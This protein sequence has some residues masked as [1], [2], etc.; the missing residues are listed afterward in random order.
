MPDNEN[1]S[2]IKSRQRVADHSEVFTNLRKVNVMLGLMDS[3][4]PIEAMLNVIPQYWHNSICLDK[5]AIQKHLFG[6]ANG[7][8]LR[9]WRSGFRCAIE[10]LTLASAWIQQ[11]SQA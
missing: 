2:Q 5:K 3:T 4:V 11:N 9:H 10:P 8:I 7:Q 6:R 1:K